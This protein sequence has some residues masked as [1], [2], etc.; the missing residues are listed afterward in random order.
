MKREREEA[1]QLDPQEVLVDPCNRDGAPPNVMYIH[2]GILKGMKDLG[3]DPARPKEGICVHYTSPAGLA[4]L[5]E[6]N[7]GSTVP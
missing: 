1:K 4:R 7:K 2:T 3:F 6:H 5:L